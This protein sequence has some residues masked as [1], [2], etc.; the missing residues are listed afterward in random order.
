MQLIPDLLVNFGPR[1]LLAL[2]G[3]ITL[4]GGV[5]F[6]DRTWD[7]KGSK[8]Y[9]KAK[10]KHSGD[11][12]VII[13]VED[14]DAAFPFPI[15]F[16]LGWIILA[17]AFLFPTNGSTAI[18]LSPVNILGAVLCIALAFIASVP[19]G[20]AVRNRNASL[21]QKLSLAF[22]LSWIGLTIVSGFSANAGTPSFVFCALGMV[23]IV[24]SMKILWKHRKMGDT[25]EQEGK[26]NP[27]PVVY[28][29]GG[30]LFVLV[31]FY[32]GSG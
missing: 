5:W 20:D 1:S 6:V 22:V 23:C 29:L 17:I 7:E 2:V 27:H 8:A 9:E 31:G 21:K 13:P 25:W 28:N 30:P 11:G 18:E 3:I 26:P 16:I 4:I 19:M 24:A 15:V 14:L 32:S 10:S 12:E